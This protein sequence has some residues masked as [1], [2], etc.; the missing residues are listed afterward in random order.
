M[1]IYKIMT[2]AQISM[3]LFIIAVALS[4]IAF[5]MYENSSKKKR[6]TH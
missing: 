5:K 6:V 4:A 3:S 1:D 2:G